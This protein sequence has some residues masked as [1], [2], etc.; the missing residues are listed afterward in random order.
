MGVKPQQSRGL[1]GLLP[2]S[3]WAGLVQSGIRHT[4]LRGDHLIRQG[5]EG[6][7]ILLLVSGRAKVVFAA[8]DGSEVLLAVRGP[9][10]I[11]GEFA[12][13]DAGPRSASVL[14]IEPCIAYLLAAAAFRGFVRRHASEPRLDRYIGA[15]LRESTEHSW[16]LSTQRPET[17]LAGL[18]LAVSAAAGPDHP[19]PYSVPMTQE[20]L[21]RGLGL[22]R[23]SV[24]AVLAGWKQ[25]GLILVGRSVL[26]IADVDG[27]RG[28][29]APPPGR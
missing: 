14:A 11:L 23:S 17:Q 9:G 10:D 26:R 24:T 22:S 13:R 21:A 1:R 8:A 2:V 29:A 12:L 25:R 5:D 19:D 7:W 16:R 3:E 20:E 4:Y 27:L 6:Q 18:M 28:V 15:K